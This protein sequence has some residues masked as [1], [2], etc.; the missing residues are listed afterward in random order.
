MHGSNHINRYLRSGVDEFLLV[1]DF[2]G[3]GTVDIVPSEIGLLEDSSGD[4]AYGLRIREL[5][6]TRLSAHD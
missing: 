5:I 3:L 1:A 4:A 6:S 2:R